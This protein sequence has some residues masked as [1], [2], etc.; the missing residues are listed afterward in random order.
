M[1][2]LVDPSHEGRHLLSIRSGAFL[3]RHFARVE[4]VNDFPPMIGNRRGREVR[5]NQINAID[6]RPGCANYAWREV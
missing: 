2:L 1:Q 6:T 5:P 4:A 3:G